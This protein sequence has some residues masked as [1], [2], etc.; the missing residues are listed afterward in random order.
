MHPEVPLKNRFEP[1]LEEE[2]RE[3]VKTKIEYESLLEKY[4]ATAYFNGHDHC[5]E[6]IDEGLGVQ[7]HTIGSAHGW[8]TSTAHASAIPK[9]SLKFHPKN[10]LGGHL[11]SD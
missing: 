7:Y 6:Y 9:G 8:D 4:N 11:L 3:D 10:G 5:A 2:P 1:L